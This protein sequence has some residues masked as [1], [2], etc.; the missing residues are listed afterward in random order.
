MLLAMIRI[1]VLMMIMDMNDI[2]FFFILFPILLHFLCQRFRPFLLFRDGRPLL[3][4]PCL[5]CPAFFFHFCIQVF[6]LVL[7]VFVNDLYVV[8]EDFVVVLFCCLVWTWYWSDYWL[9]IIL[10]SAYDGMACDVLVFCRFFLHWFFSFSSAYDGMACPVA[11]SKANLNIR[12]VSSPHI[13]FPR[14]VSKY[15]NT[16]LENK[17][18]TTEVLKFNLWKSFSS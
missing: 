16:L 15:H 18:P 9:N 11:D 1:V 14:E 7:L 6:L 12:N 13:T 2:I 3:L 10:F 5:H 8:C 4:T 17:V